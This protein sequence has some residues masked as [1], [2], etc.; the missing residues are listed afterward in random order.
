ML[1]G[2][3]TSFFFFLLIMLLIGVYAS[4]R[5]KNEGSYLLAN[6]KVGLFA[7]TAT[8]VMTE[9][10]T[11]TLLA[12]SSFGHSVGWWGLSMASVFL[13]GLLF[14]AGTVANKWKEFNGVSV[15]D[16]FRQKYG[17]DVGKMVACLLFTTML[18]FSATYVKSL[19]LIFHPLFPDLNLW[20]LSGLLVF[21]ILSMTLKG[22][23]ISIIWTDVFSFLCLVLFFPVLFWYVSQNSGNPAEPYSLDDAIA[24]LPPQFVF[25]LIL[26]TMFSYILAPWYGQK[27]IAA[28]S[29]KV[30]VMSVFLSAL[31]VA[32]FYGLS[33]AV[34]AIY[35]GKAPTLLDNALALPTVMNEV[36]PHSLK[37][38]GVGI[39][40][41]IAATTLSG[42]WSAMVTIL[43]TNG[44]RDRSLDKNKSSS[45]GIF[46]T[47]LCAFASY[48][49]ANTF[50]DNIL[51][52]MILANIPIVSLSFALLGGFYW[53]RA[54]KGGVYS[55]FFC[56]LAYGIFLYF[57][58]HNDMTYIWDFTV[59]GIPLIFITGTA[60]SIFY[61]KRQKLG[62]R[63]GDLSS[64]RP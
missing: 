53:K 16:Y 56:G 31:I 33:I 19:S 28:K 36:L 57:Y 40:F 49:C 60:G 2:E 25:S 8:L 24:K 18:L 59:Y 39:L 64:P 14:Y 34:T 30:A 10:N 22:G 5:V 55:S 4:R 48:L 46:L 17:S 12:F 11:S 26:M 1:S 9:L 32:L 58:H 35:R 62:L 15:A 3:Y 27:V 43:I 63:K 23:L 52:K 50:I 54:N 21:L 29:K 44:K 20:V 61:D 45:R 7:L 38:V 42:V 51:D 6:R 41:C 47:A 13:V 37:G